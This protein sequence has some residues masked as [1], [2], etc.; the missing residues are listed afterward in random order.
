M[1]LRQKGQPRNQHN[2]SNVWFVS[3]LI[4]DPLIETGEDDKSTQVF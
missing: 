3:F 1:A 2:Q 4:A